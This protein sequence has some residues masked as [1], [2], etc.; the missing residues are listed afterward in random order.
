MSPEALTTLRISTMASES[1]IY[2]SKYGPITLLSRTNYTTWKS[3][4]SAVLLAANALD[5]VLG[6]SLAPPN[7]ASQAGQDW[8]KRKG[9]ALSLLYQSTSPE[10]KNTLATYLENRDVT[11]LWEHLATFDLSLNGVYALKLVQEFELESFKPTDT[12]E[13]YSQRLLSYQL[14]LQSSKYPINDPQLVLRLCIGMPNTLNWNNTRQAVLR[15]DCTFQEAVAQFQAAKRPRKPAE[16]DTANFA[17]DGSKSK[18]NG[19]RKSKKVGWRK[20]KRNAS[21]KASGDES[22]Q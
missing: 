14:N 18:R 9:I 10:I 19:R 1:S 22:Y 7:L 8:S 20:S 15:K 17:R 16:P 2:S 12:I 13:S 5:I 4:I 3:D 6:E 21:N 11:G